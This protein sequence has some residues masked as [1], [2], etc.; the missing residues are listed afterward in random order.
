MCHY[1][2]KVD[3]PESYDVQIASTFVSRLVLEKLTARD[4]K[5]RA[6]L[7]R[8]LQGTPNGA[9]FCGLLFEMKAHEQL[10]RGGGINTQCLSEMEMPM[11]RFQLNKSKEFCFFD[12]KQLSSAT[13]Q[14][15]SPYHISRATNFE[16]VDSFYC[17]RR[18]K[19]PTKRKL[20]IFEMTVAL[21]NPAKGMGIVALLRA[22]GWLDKAL[23]GPT[24]VALI[25][26]CV[27]DSETDMKHKQRVQW[28][29][30]ADGESV[31]VI[32][33]FDD[34]NTTALGRLMSRHWGIFAVKFPT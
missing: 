10:V 33:S 9:A 25:F 12:H 30:A 6:D 1:Q 23:E 17:P 15:R 32:S 34:T 2:P 21:K 14:E 26:V 13:L 29:P 4:F 7:L 18:P 22:V 24:R 19:F 20:L 5:K 28:A 27:D 31:N 16:S 3:D 8:L 11:K